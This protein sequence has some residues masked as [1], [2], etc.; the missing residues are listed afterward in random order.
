[1]TPKANSNTSSNISTKPTELITPEFPH[2]QSCDNYS[3]DH[4]QSFSTD[5][6]SLE[7]SADRDPKNLETQQIGQVNKKDWRTHRGVLKNLYLSQRKPL[8][9]VMKIMA[10]KYNF[11]PTAKQY[12]YQLVKWGW[13]KYNVGGYRLPLNPSD[14]NELSGRHLG[15]TT[16][17]NAFDPPLP[18]EA[19]TQPEDW[20][21]TQNS[22]QDSASYCSAISEKPAL[23]QDSDSTSDYMKSNLDM[24][25][26]Y[27]VDSSDQRRQSRIT[28]NWEMSYDLPTG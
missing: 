18:D 28:E 7:S 22:G 19:Y 24:D 11:K 14:F 2:S 10:D 13:K 1:M 5:C 26:M 17:P 27:L 12:R 16:Y 15:T 9:E 25:N 20:M 3:Q 23:Q 6:T 4:T 8:A 21:L